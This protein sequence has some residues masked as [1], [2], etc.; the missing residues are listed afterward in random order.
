[1][2]DPL[3][4]LISEY[5]QGSR[6]VYGPKPEIT[7]VQGKF[8]DPSIFG[9][10]LFLAEMMSGWILKPISGV[11]QFGTLG[12]IKIMTSSIV[13]IVRKGQNLIKYL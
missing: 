9:V 11:C 8:N 5:F 3:D 10:E 13:S 6:G 12:Q 2:Y 1:M 7:I 4:N